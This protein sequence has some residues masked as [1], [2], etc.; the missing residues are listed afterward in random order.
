SFAFADE[1]GDKAATAASLREYWTMLCY[2][3]EKGQALAARIPPTVLNKDVNKA[4]FADLDRYDLNP[5]I[6]KFKFPTLVI[7]GRYDINVA[8]V[9]AYKI[10][11]G[12]PGSKF[13]VFERSGHFPF[14][15]EPEAFVKAV[16]EFLAGK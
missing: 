4:V 15:E 8:P 2:S 10:H 5:E 7:T 12:I 14:Y 11:Q 3:P 13:L 16:E 6:R 1:L 9:V